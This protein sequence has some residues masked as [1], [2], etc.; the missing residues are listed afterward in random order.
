MIQ[1]LLK[2]LMGMEDNGSSILQD[3]P[4]NG[5]SFIAYQHFVLFSTMRWSTS[6]MDSTSLF[7]LTLFDIK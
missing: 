1:K 6:L 7:A 3:L 2:M 5:D 4:L